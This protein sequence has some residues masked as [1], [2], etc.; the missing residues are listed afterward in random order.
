MQWLTNVLQKLN[1][2][3]SYL[4]C[5]KMISVPPGQIRESK[6]VL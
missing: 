3:L 6:D 5:A 1:S 2:F 4:V